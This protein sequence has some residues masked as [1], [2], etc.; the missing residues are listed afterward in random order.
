MD[1]HLDRVIIAS[2]DDRLIR[3]NEGVTFTL[4]LQ[5]IFLAGAYAVLFV[6]KAC[7]LRWFCSV[8]LLA[9]V[10]KYN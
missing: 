7:R 9:T 8:Y 1:I 4:F 6:A 2:D 10:H 5:T 3:T